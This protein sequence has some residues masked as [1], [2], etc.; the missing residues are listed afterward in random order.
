MTH[1]SELGEDQCFGPRGLD[2]L[3]HFA[4]TAAL[5]GTVS[6]GF[7]INTNFGRIRVTFDQT[8]VIA[9]LLETNQHRQ[10][11]ASP[12]NAFG[13]SQFTH[14][15]GNRLLVQGGLFW[16][17][18]GVLDG[19]GARRQVIDDRTVGFHSAQDE[20][21][22]HLPQPLRTIS[23]AVSFDGYRKPAAEFP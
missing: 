3:Q 7:R 11:Q 16:S 5:A 1:S 12:A 2:L 10:H 21:T 23:I 20:R 22:N 4:K 6:D 13:F 17:Q 15:A 9:D 14:H 8:W 19:R 18:S